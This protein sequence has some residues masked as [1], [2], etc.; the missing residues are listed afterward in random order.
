MVLISGDV[1]C[2]PDTCI[3]NITYAYKLLM[4]ILCRYFNVFME[5]NF[6]AHVKKRYFL[7]SPAGTAAENILYLVRMH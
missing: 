2:Q 1:N 4:I 3:L 5:T 7:R 6:S